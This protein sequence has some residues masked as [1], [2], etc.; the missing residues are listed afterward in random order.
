MQLRFYSDP[1]TGEPH[2]HDHGVLEAEVEEILRKPG[3]DFPG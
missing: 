1:E 2:I 3:D